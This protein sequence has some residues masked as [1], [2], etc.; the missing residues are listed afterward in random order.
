MPLGSELLKL[1]N[2]LPVVDSLRLDRQRIAA[3][4]RECVGPMS[5]SAVLAS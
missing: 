4:V 2:L 3:S 1:I 5:S